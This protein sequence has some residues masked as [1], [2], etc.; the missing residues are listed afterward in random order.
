MAAATPAD[1]EPQAGTPVE[2][3]PSV[4]RVTAPNAGPYTDTGTNSYIIGDD[5]VAVLDP[6]PAH[7]SHLRALMRVIDGREVA[8]IL[9]THT[10][11]DHSALAP[12]LRQATRAPLMFNGRHRLSRP[13][14]WLEVNPV[15][16]HSD[17]RLKPDRPFGEGA[18]VAAGGMRLVGIATPGHCANHLC[19]GIEG[20]PWLL[21]GDHVMGW[22]S[23]LVAVPD[24]SMENY[25]ASLRKL[26]T[27]PYRQYLPG[28]GHPVSEGPE[29]ARALLEHR[30]ARN[31]QVREAVAA[32][33]TD[34][35]GLVRAVYPELAPPLVP[36][37]RMTLE[38]HV[39]YLEARGDLVVR[40]GPLGLR[41]A[42][43]S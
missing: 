39:E 8:A 5:T 18:V 36:A 15:G 25:L 40:R 29:R 23:T 30:E 7:P 38:A 14:R 32:G 19:I 16:G 3:A 1:P 35:G 2:V 4:V 21:S 24:G 27:L 17:W 37:A 34:I 43:S 41:L 9:L 31:G 42:A 26:E 33:V 12:G 11:K 6:G 10:H 13:A 20:T 28:H 22:N